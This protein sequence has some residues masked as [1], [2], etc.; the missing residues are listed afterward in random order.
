MNISYV[1]EDGYEK[2]KKELDYLIKDRR[3]EI[4]QKIAT[5]REHGDL[6]ENAEYDAAKEEQGFNELKIRELSEKLA[7]AR[8]LDEKEIPHD[9]VYL[10]ATI[11]LLNLKDQEETEYTLVSEVEADIMDHKISVASPLGKGLLGHSEN[12]EVT[13]EVPAGIMK[14]KI[15]KITR[16]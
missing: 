6:R 16:G 10:G 4:A 12:D 1:T 5:A 15:L 14:Y 2:L 3:R 8:I 11:R 9:K 7:T 13:I